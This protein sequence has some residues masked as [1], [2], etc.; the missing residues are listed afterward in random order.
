MNVLT[1]GSILWIFSSLPLQPQK[2]KVGTK[3]QKQIMEENTQTLNFYR[4][5][6]LGSNGLFLILNGF[7][8]SEFATSEIVSIH[9]STFWYDIFTNVFWLT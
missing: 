3:G 1:I 8:F 6:I 7:V 5:M 9:V 4:I 2:G